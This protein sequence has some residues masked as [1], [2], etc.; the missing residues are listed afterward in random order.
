MVSPEQIE[1]RFKELIDLFPSPY[2]EIF[3][4]AISEHKLVIWTDSKKIDEYQQLFG[5]IRIAGSINGNLFFRL[6][7]I[8]EDI[9]DKVIIHELIH[10]YLE[11][12]DGLGYKDFQSWLKIDLL[13]KAKTERLIQQNEMEAQL[14]TQQVLNKIGKS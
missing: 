11:Q 12:R 10:F 3:D 5:K 7:R 2:K 6:D 9:L 14:L 13:E 4:K 1:K 8:T